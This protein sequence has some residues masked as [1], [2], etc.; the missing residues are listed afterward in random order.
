VH[1]VKVPGVNHLLAAAKTG[2]VDEYGTLEEK[3]V[4]PLVVAAIVDWLKVT[5]A[6]VR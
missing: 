2:A 6:A 3:R 4:S 1:V 5:F